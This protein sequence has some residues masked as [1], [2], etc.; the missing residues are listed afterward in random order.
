[1]NLKF[2]IFLI[3]SIEDC[4]TIVFNGFNKLIGITLNKLSGNI[5]D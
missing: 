2:N 1:M 3:Q 5:W 4:E